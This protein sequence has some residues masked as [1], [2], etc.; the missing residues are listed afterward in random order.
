MPTLT[1]P[2]APLIASPARL[3]ALYRLAL[4]MLF[5]PTGLTERVQQLLIDLTGGKYPIR[6]DRVGPPI[7]LLLA[8]VAALPCLLPPPDAR[9]ALRRLVHTFAGGAVLLASQTLIPRYWLVPLA[10][11]TVLVCRRQSPPM[12]ATYCA[13][14]FLTPVRHFATPMF[15]AHVLMLLAVLDVVAAFRPGRTGGHNE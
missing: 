5:V 1:T 10:L 13:A 15:A 11:A 14:V 7:L 3:V 6:V 9:G 12:L 2:P 8:G 4:L